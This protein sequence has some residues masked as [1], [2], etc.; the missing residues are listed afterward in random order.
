MRESR[1]DRMIGRTAAGLLLL[2]VVLAV[3]G[4]AATAWAQAAAPS[5][6]VDFFGDVVHVVQKWQTVGWLAA[7]AALAGFGVKVLVA[8][9]AGRAWLDARG[10]LP[11]VAGGLGALA[12]AL[13]A[14]AA[15]QSD[16][17]L[18]AAASGYMAGLAMVGIN[19]SAKQLGAAKAE[20]AAERA[21]A[22]ANTPPS[23]PPG[24]RPPAA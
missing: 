3:L 18:T 15:G 17:I 23:L 8:W 2:A 7:I 19:Q 16:Q 4:A 1:L 10:L 12:G 21:D 20:R 6:E 24:V 5:G 22:A 9:P 11:Q 14:L 13:G